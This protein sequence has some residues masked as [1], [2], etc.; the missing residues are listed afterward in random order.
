MAAKD[1]VTASKLYYYIYYFFIA[2]RTMAPSTISSS[3][4]RLPRDL[5]FKKHV[6]MA[7]PFAGL[8]TWKL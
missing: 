3:Q 7:K 8:A 5:F 2:A 1:W 4:E 6:A